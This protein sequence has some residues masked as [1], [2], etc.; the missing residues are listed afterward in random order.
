MSEAYDPREYWDARLA[1]RWD[2][3]GVGHL[4]YSLRYNEWLYRAQGR[5]LA[6]ALRRAGVA[7]SNWDV[8]DVGSGTGHWLAWYGRRG[9]GPLTA[10]EL[11]AAAARRLREV[12]P[13]A[14]VVE[15]DIAQVAPDS[16][17]FGLV[18]VLGVVYHIVEPL[19]IERALE[20]LACLT[21][22]GGWLV[23]SDALGPREMRPAPHVRFR[24][25][26]F[27]EERLPP[28]G[29]RIEVVEPVYTLLNG[30]LSQAARTAP[31]AV[32]RRVRAA[33]DKLAGVLF[34]LD[35]LPGLGRW[36]NMRLMLANKVETLLPGGAP[37][38]EPA[39]PADPR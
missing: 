12:F 24:P 13:R 28:L 9:A 2:L 33:E 29:F 34:L 30:G 31:P 14:T 16:P 26:D 37:Q 18:N 39:P 32:R 6:R 10:L 5:A 8:L 7:V 23:L 4:G 35:R 15:S 25:L 19:A 21:A 27:Y 38:D 11:S 22:P 36:A 17:R 1:A 3:S 20:N